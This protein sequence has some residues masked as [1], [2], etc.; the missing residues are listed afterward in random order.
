MN[1]EKNFTTNT[2]FQETLKRSGIRITPQRLE[3]FRAVADSREHPDA[4]TVFKIVRK[5]VPSMSLDTV[6]RT[7][8]M[9]DDLGLI[10]TVNTRSIEKHFDGN[11]RPHHHFVCRICGS[12][13]DFYSDELEKLNI[14]AS[15]MEIGNAEEMKIEITGICSNCLNENKSLK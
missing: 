15:A 7:L 8:R 4:E 1:N 9:L 6:Y 14:P 5:K 13:T 11:L 2:D 3:I 10:K 12:L